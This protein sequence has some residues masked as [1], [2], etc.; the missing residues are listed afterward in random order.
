MN[1]NS[2]YCETDMVEL[3][4]IQA[5]VTNKSKKTMD[6]PSYRSDKL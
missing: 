1:N 5:S 4:I 3:C 6:A 2:N